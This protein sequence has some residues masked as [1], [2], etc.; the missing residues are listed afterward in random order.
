MVAGDRRRPAASNAAETVMGSP[1]NRTADRARCSIGPRALVAR[2]RPPLRP[3]LAEAGNSS[4]RRL[5]I[6]HRKRLV[7]FGG[8]DRIGPG[9]GSGGH[10]RGVAVVGVDRMLGG[11]RVGGWGVP[12]GRVMA[13]VVPRESPDA[14]AAR[15]VED[16]VRAARG[17]W[18]VGRLAEL[19]L[20]RCA[21]EAD[22]PPYSVLFVHGPGGV[23]K[24]ALLQAFWQL[25]EDA[26]LDPVRLDL[27]GLEP[28]PAGFS[29]ALAAAL[30][31]E[32]AESLMGALAGRRRVVL[33]LD[34]FEQ[35]V[36]LEDWLRERFVPG[37]PAGAI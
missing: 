18:F 28:S 26:R 5:D 14:R 17:R 29:A 27:R 31:L 11:A 1:P 34:T 33:L 2:V 16:R 20:F 6:V 4:D 9:A 25:A 30:G 32:S 19:E 10:F 3:R 12:A 7:G 23:G 15:T 8:H 21:L 37:L 13:E 22:E 24:T 35:G 36:G